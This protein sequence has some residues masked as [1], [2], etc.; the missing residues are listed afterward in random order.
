MVCSKFPE[1]FVSV[2]KLL[3]KSTSPSGPLQI[4]AGAFRHRSEISIG[5]NEKLRLTLTG[6]HDKFEFVDHSEDTIGWV[7]SCSFCL[8]EDKRSGVGAMMW[9]ASFQEANAGASTIAPSTWIQR[10]IRLWQYRV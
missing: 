1:E 10:K 8:A 3:D 6:V 5:C 4:G 2:W 7:A 9:L